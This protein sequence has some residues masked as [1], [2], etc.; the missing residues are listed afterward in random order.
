[1]NKWSGYNLFYDVFG[2]FLLQLLVRQQPQTVGYPLQPPNFRP[3]HHHQ[4][5]RLNRNQGCP[6]N[7]HDSHDV[8]LLTSENAVLL[9]NKFQKQQLQRLQ[10]RQAWLFH[11]ILVL[12]RLDV[13]FKVVIHKLLLERHKKSRSL[14]DNLK[15]RKRVEIH[16]LASFRD[17][18][19]S[20]DEQIA[21][22]F[23]LSI[24]V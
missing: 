1:M 11:Q 10:L 2:L 20:L 12:R 8:L 23:V 13:N 5:R 14:L 17:E 9:L 7:Y 6:H 24:L 16:V 21:Q 22:G 19:F 3:V 18:S 4:R 15:Q